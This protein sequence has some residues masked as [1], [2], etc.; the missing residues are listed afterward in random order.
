MPPQAQ[1]N[2]LQLN[3]MEDELKDLCPLELMLISRIIPF[4][5]IVPKHKGAQFGLKGQCVLV[6]ADLKK[7]ETSLPRPCDLNCVISLALKRRLSD[8]SYHRKQNI[9]PAKVNRTLQ[10]LREINQF[11]AD[12][13]IHDTWENVSQDSDPEL[14]ELLTNENAKPDTADLIDSDEE[15]ERN[16]HT[17]E[18][19]SRESNVPHPTVLHNENGTNVSSG[20]VLN[21]APGE[22]Q[23]PVSFSSEPDWEALAFIKEFSLGRYH[24]NEERPVRITPSQYVHTRLKCADDRFAQNPQYIFAELDMIER[25]AILSSITF[26]ESKR[27]QD[28]ATVADVNSSCTRRMLNDQQI[29]YTFKN[30]RGT[31]QFCRNQMLD[32]LAKVR[33]FGC[34][35]FF[36]TL[37]AGIP[38]FWPEIFQILGRQYGKNF[39]EQDVNGM[40]NNEKISWL[41]KNPV[42]VARQVD[43]LFT[44]MLGSNVIMSGMHPIGQ[45]LNF[46]ERREFQMRGVEH[47]HVALHVKDA[48]KLDKDPDS[49]VIE[50]IDKF[51]T[52]SEP[53]TETEPEL[54]E[55]VTS[56]WTHRHTFTCRKKKGVR[57]RFNAPWPP[58]DRT[59][60]LRGEN[61]TNEEVKERRRHC[62]AFSYIML[63]SILHY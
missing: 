16:D 18:R 14:W 62:A 63:H 5:F 40:S 11:Y 51:I 47:T 55:L 42:T 61:L 46:D 57:C 48:P 56:R 4:M 2:S 23:I 60:I 28:N 21:V 25:A 7:I 59:I 52:V 1:A 12:V 35:T 49:E 6:P 33:Q 24:F 44:K 27:F 43:Y 50:F 3:K 19:E 13:T 36:L 22:G 53:N 37:S 31:P 34:Y 15:I 45:I 26:A 32:V 20:E 8:K 54:H 39:T 30:I 9:H 38:H 58:S 17:L 29:Y 41:K 10:K